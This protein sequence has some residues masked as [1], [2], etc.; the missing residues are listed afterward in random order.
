MYAIR[1]YYVG[2]MGI[3]VSPVNPNYVY[4]I[5]EAA[6]DKGGFFRSTDKGESWEKMSSY[7]SSGQYYNEIV[8]DP[9]D[10]DKV[11]STETVSKVTVDGGK[12][13]TSIS[14][15]GRHVDDHAIWIDPSDTEHF[16]IGGDGGIYETWDNGSTFDYKENLPVTQFYRV[17]VDNAKP[18]NNFV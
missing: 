15:R 13:W 2:G 3:D 18:R 5:M 9:K 4:L 1:S 11:Y 10:V 8:C 7:H 17:N 12:N 6:D 16:M 14:T